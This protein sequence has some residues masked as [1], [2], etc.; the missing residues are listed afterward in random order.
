MNYSVN[1]S[2]VTKY[3]EALASQSVT[4]ENTT[5]TGAQN[6][7]K[8]ILIIENGLKELRYTLNEKLSLLTQRKLIVEKRILALKE[9]LYNTD[10]LQTRYVEYKD[11]V[12]TVTTSV[13]SKYMSLIQ[14]TIDL[15]VDLPTKQ[16]Y[17]LNRELTA[18]TY[19]VSG[20]T[21]EIEYLRE[22][23]SSL[24]ELKSKIDAL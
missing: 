17:S 6:L 22:L 20:I 23:D 13:T 11:N 24:V 7:K 3:L 21:T 5:V 1:D 19:L 14:Q 2:D 10:S 9:D 16:S 12:K 4:V 18:L 8:I 15:Q